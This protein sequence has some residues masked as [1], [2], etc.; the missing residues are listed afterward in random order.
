M[1]SIRE[2]GQGTFE[3]KDLADEFQTDLQ[4]DL[5]RVESAGL[6]HEVIAMMPGY[7]GGRYDGTSTFDRLFRIVE[8]TKEGAA[9]PENKVK[10]KGLREG[11]E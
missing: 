9:K 11:I 10:E 7:G 8:A 2:R 5:K 4:L 1:G 6:I 3:M